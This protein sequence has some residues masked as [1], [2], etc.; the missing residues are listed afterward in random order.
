VNNL[1]NGLYNPVDWLND[2]VGA[3]SIGPAAVIPV[4]NQRLPPPRQ[5]EQAQV[6]GQHADH[7]HSSAAAAWSSSGGSTP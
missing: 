1:F 4:S 5:R 7:N 2:E 3:S 6:Q